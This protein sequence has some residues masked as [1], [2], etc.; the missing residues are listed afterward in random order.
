MTERLEDFG[1]RWHAK[2]EALV[3][4]D[5]SEITAENYLT[6]Q[7]MKRIANV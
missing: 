3:E 7:N 4:E 5:L 2:A 6:E 1:D